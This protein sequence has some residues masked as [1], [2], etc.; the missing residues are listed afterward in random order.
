[1]DNHAVRQFGV[2]FIDA[3]TGWIGA[4][5]HGLATTDGGQTWTPATFGNAVNKI[6]LVRTPTGVTG[7]AIGVDV[8]RMR[9]AP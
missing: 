7:Y 9:M 2:G 6:R 1:V 5:P 3:Q 8:H 4:V